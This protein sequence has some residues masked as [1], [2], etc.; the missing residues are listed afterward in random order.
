VG[1]DGA[2]EGT[3][4]GMPARLLPANP[5]R[6][7]TWQDCPA[8]YRLTYLDKA[9]KG[10]PWAHTSFGIAVHNALRDW[11]SLPL[12][13]RTGDAAAGLV[14]RA[15]VPLGFR[16]DA[17]AEQWCEEAAAMVR[18]YVAGL[19]PSDEPVGV[20]RTVSFRTDVMTMQGRVDRIDRRASEDGGEELVIVDYKTGR[21]VLSTTDARS[22]T[23]LAMYAVAAQRTLRTRCRRVELHH[24]PTGDVVVWEHA[25]ES[26]RRHVSRAEDVAR[27]AGS[28]EAAWR[29]ADGALDPEVQEQ[30]FPARPSALC[31]YCDVVRSCPAGIASTGGLLPSAWSVMDRFE[32]G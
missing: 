21:H 20:E 10:P 31:G 12:P 17:H 1:D 28:A 23:A 27:E 7:A 24:L 32:V 13:E 22:S 25:Q 11:W 6:L 26:L 2:G 14:R 8:R 16:D 9:P 4:A 3:L 19:D 30:V 15:W 29:A 18:R 5:T